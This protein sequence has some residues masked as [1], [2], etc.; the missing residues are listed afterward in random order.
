MIF[1]ILHPKLNP[2]DTWTTGT[3]HLH[4]VPVCPY[5][6]EVVNQITSMTF[7]DALIASGYVLDEDNF[8]D[9]SYEKLSHEIYQEL[10]NLSYLNDELFDYYCNE[11]FYPDNE[12]EM[13]LEKCT[14]ELL[15]E[16]RQIVD[17]NR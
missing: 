15:L 3:R 10:D 1:S 9:G 7:T 6:A 17:D 12:D 14:P 13:I 2:C 8:D 11:L 4:P 16:L 5:N